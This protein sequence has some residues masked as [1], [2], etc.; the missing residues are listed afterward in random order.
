MYGTWI[1]RTTTRAEYLKDR[2]RVR[3][4]QHEISQIVRAAKA[5]EVADDEIDLPYAP[6]SHVYRYV[7]LPAYDSMMERKADRRMRLF[8]KRYHFS[9]PKH[10][11]PTHPYF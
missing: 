9:K 1:P 11:T 6:M 4:H 5:A 10:E 8:V 3:D 7:D 2:R